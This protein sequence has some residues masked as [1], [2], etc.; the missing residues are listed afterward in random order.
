MMLL[1]MLLLCPSL[2][3]ADQ[4]RSDVCLPLVIVSENRHDRE[5]GWERGSRHTRRWDD[6]DFLCSLGR[7]QPLG[8]LDKPLKRDSWMDG[9]RVL[10]KDPGA[11]HAQ[12]AS[13]MA[14]PGRTFAC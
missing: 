10:S 14:P 8:V 6:Q 7:E 2:R 4:I 3:V 13:M 9:T 1:L 12:I 11:L 5:G